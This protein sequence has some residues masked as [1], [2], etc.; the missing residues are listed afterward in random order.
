MQQPSET[1]FHRLK[2]SG[3]IYNREKCIFSDAL[4]NKSFLYFPSN[5]RMQ[6]PA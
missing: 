3:V 4:F 6:Q 2:N 1:D 5:L